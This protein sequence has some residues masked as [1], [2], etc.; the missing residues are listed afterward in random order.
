MNRNKCFLL[1]F[2]FAILLG[3]CN[4]GSSNSGSD[5]EEQDKRV[6]KPIPKQGTD[7]E[8]ATVWEKK[9]TTLPVKCEGDVVIGQGIV[10][11]ERVHERESVDQKSGAE[12]ADD[13][14]DDTEQVEPLNQEE[15]EDDAV[16]ADLDGKRPIGAIHVGAMGTQEEGTDPLAAE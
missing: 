8:E 2:V 16:E 6:A 12:D 11:H 10:W 13:A 5:R 15:G 7:S 9:E 3:G 4:P 1:A 14:H